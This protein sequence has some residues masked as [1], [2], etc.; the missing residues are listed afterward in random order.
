VSIELAARMKLSL[1]PLGH[2]YTITGYDRGQV[3]IAE[4]VLTRS[5]IVAPHRLLRDWP[6]QEFAE[7][8][9]E[10]LEWVIR[11][12]P[13][14]VLLGTGARL[15]FPDPRI[16]FPVHSRQVGL[17]VMDTGAACRTYNVLTAEGRRVVAA[18]LL[19]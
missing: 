8:Q 17:E 7:L 16:T 19:A 9:C 15:R 6:P 10:H 3:V 11:L 18:L 5:V 13:E 2:A 12:E 1:D 14:I 4:E